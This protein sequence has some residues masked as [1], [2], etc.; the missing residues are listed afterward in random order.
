MKGVIVGTDHNQEWMLSWWWN[1][2]SKHNT[3][4]VAFADFGMTS[5]ARTWCEE[6]G[7]VYP[8]TL[9]P[10][11]IASKE[12]F[13]PSMLKIWEK[14]IV[15]YAWQARMSWFKKPLALLNSPF[16]T[17]IWLDLDCEVFGNVEPIFDYINHSGVA[18]VAEHATIQ[19]KYQNMGSHFLGEIGYNSGVIAFHRNAPLLKKWAELAFNQNN[20][21]ISDQ[22][23]LSRVIFNEGYLVGQLPDKYNWLM[24]N[25]TFPE[26]PVI[27]HWAGMPKPF[28]KEFGLMKDISLQL[29]LNLVYQNLGES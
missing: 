7:P 8:V 28:L 2:Y 14:N 10:E 25:P 20:Q 3:L 15:S 9:D 5:E 21:F 12:H 29:R 1:N 27:I 17:G 18:L 13:D 16:E 6:R 4:T 11:K 22:D 23:A 19:E 24:V 26:D